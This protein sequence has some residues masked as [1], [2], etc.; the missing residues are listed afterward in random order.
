MIARIAICYGGEVRTRRRRAALVIAS[1][2]AA[3]GALGGV[4]GARAES[5]VVVVPASR[6]AAA[7]DDV[8][9]AIAAAGGG[10]VDALARARA[11]RAAGAVPAGELEGFAQVARLE[12]E[13]WRAYQAVDAAFAASR[14]AAAR[15]QAEALLALPG[16]PE[17][18][19]E[20]SLRLGLVLAHL[21]RRDE[22]AE[23]LRLAH[24]L[25]PGRVVG[26]A[27]FSPDGVAAYQ[28]AI[29]A[30]PPTV[31]VTV[32]ATARARLTID[33]EDAGAAPVTRPLAV[34]QHVIVARAPGWIARGEAVLIGAGTK[35]VRIELDAAP[36]GGA[37]A[38]DGAL[39]AGAGE[40]EAGAAVAEVLTYAELDELFVVASVYRG[41]GPALVGQR[42]ALAR[43]ACTAIGEVG[44]VD[45]GLDAAARALVEQLR[46][47]ELRYGVLVPSDP[48]VTRGERGGGGETACR[49]CRDRRVLIGGG[50]LVV[51]LITA[52]TLVLTRDE[53]VPA[54]AIDPGDF[55][56]E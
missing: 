36:G 53:P 1:V 16:G 55:V 31:S 5:G 23:V 11:A 17:A 40:G 26:A 19:A 2:I 3:A 33:G 29:A 37:L 41:G 45:G 30:T 13:G 10:E 54:V 27:E 15:A 24:A 18:Y 8:A 14:L 12:A 48:R 4:G 34:G 22:A 51:G 21:G 39:A 44:H 32:N 43:P 38:R 9:R 35:D 20:V 25:D 56:M 47:A 49:W 6:P 52:A 7:A 28:A 46:G 50:V 42:C